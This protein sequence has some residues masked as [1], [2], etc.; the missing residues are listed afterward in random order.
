M[1]TDPTA[2]PPEDAF[3]PATDPN[4]LD[5]GQHPDPQG[6]SDSLRDEVAALA[7]EIF[8]APEEEPSEASASR[9][10]VHSD[11]AMPDRVDPAPDLLQDDPSWLYEGDDLLASAPT[12]GIGD[13]SLLGSTSTNL[14]GGEEHPG[15]QTEVHFFEQDDE[16][17]K[18]T[19]IYPV[20]SELNRS[21]PQPEQAAVPSDDAE[22]AIGEDDIPS[23]PWSDSQV[24][25]GHS[26]L[27]GAFGNAEADSGVSSDSQ[28]PV[29]NLNDPAIMTPPPLAVQPSSD[30]DA[31]DVDILGGLDDSSGPASG[32]YRPGT[33]SAPGSKV[34]FV[35]PFGDI[36]DDDP[37]DL[38]WFAGSPLPDLPG[39]PNDSGT[40]SG[41]SV[42][43]DEVDL[44]S[45]G[46]AELAAP[47]SGFFEPLGSEPDLEPI[48][49][50]A[51]MG[52]TSDALF[53]ADSLQRPGQGG[54]DV[55]RGMFNKAAAQKPVSNIFDE[56]ASPAQDLQRTEPMSVSASANED[57]ESNQGSSMSILPSARAGDPTGSDVFDPFRP[58]K[59]DPLSGIGSGT[60]MPNTSI[61]DS[62]DLPQGPDAVQKL[63][64]EMS[65]QS[66]RRGTALNPSDAGA[67]ADG[68]PD[69]DV[70]DE[71]GSGSNL[72]ADS[73][74]PEFMLPGGSSGVNLLGALG[75]P[76]SGIFGGPQSS[77][78][79]DERRVETR[80]EPGGDGSVNVNEIPMMGST[81]DATEA[82]PLPE[83]LPSIV[84]S[85][86]P[87]DAGGDAG[88][89]SF[90]MP[91]TKKGG[92]GD[93]AHIAEAS[94]MIDWSLPAH[95]DELAP[96]PLPS[97][98]GN[99]F[100]DT[101][102]N[103][104]RS[105]V[106]LEDPEDFERPKASISGTR[107]PS[108]PRPSSLPSIDDLL[109]PPNAPEL[110]PPS[111]IV[112]MTTPVTSSRF[113][114][115]APSRTGMAASASSTMPLAEPVTI[116][117]GGWLAGSAAGLLVGLGTGAV[118]YFSGL[119][120]SPNGTLAPPPSRTLAAV[121]P[122][123]PADVVASACAGRR[124][125]A[126]PRGHGGR[127]R[128]AGG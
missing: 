56:L 121:V 104:N 77:I 90:E 119:L 63:L 125:G 127:G 122:S 61:L 60:E 115:G 32:L 86:I 38:D 10:E 35:D 117:R 25:A 109:L 7:E 98:V 2:L 87:G 51:Q 108:V 78:F 58:G 52:M 114:Q 95:D 20:L 107:P 15:A 91:W 103:R 65:G 16:S 50:P 41:S 66:S 76:P 30:W 6:V 88:R 101:D 3:N 81:D 68:T 8:S 116:R 123:A 102:N 84:A 82:F 112:S 85:E 33:P 18:F 70:L 100:S 55:I 21:A 26:H 75:G 24:F 44:L 105:S 73:T 128:A 40:R 27:E 92:S 67:G 13:S 69:F 22:S 93:A 5:A 118:A 45:A 62:G 11:D 57:G 113:P 53:P 94:G 34:S 120:P 64:S 106:L 4:A 99:I 59:R 79:T 9:T 83:D 48:V 29:E 39:S 96:G 19:D 72:F 54:S 14:A 12:Q 42:A 17:T 110:P 1:A 43:S 46:G 47:G 36:P 23:S 49:P 71:G 28:T 111:M 97:G 74:S 31:E 37:S 124:R 89:V 126:G 80:A